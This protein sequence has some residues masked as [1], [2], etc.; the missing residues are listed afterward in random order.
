[1]A[2][3]PAPQPALLDSAPSDNN[4]ATTHWGPR[5]VGGGDREWGKP[6]SK[7][8][9]PSWSGDVR[10]S[11][12]PS[13]RA[14]RAGGKASVPGYLAPVGLPARLPFDL[15]LLGLKACS[16]LRA[17][18]TATALPQQRH[19]PAAFAP[20]LHTCTLRCVSSCKRAPTTL[21]PSLL[22][23]FAARPEGAAPG[24]LHKRRPVSRRRRAGGTAGK[25]RGGRSAS[26]RPSKEKR[27][28]SVREELPN[29]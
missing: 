15:P 8:L 22:K 27:G 3:L 19:R 29:P 26:N 11:W 2:G 1:M 28:K 21:S 6:R 17:F 16:P 12:Y 4:V 7:A 25:T 13:R 14:P 5:A 20:Q 23:D 24:L 9:R 10:L 18:A